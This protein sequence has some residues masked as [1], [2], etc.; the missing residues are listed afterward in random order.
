MLHPLLGP[1]ASLYAWLGA[2]PLVLLTVAA[3]YA[4]YVIKMRLRIDIFPHW[5][6]HLHG[7]RTLLRKLKAKL[8]D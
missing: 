2:T 8:G 3:L 6:L 4:I 1:L 5:G 7:P